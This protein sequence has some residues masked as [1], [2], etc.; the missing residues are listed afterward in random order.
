MASAPAVQ[1]KESCFGGGKLISCAPLD[2]YA[3]CPDCGK[4]QLLE[5]PYLKS[6]KKKALKVHEARPATEVA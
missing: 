1:K 2:A 5:G 4:E 3:V 6:G